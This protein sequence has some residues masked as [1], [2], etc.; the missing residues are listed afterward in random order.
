ML[1]VIDQLGVATN[2]GGRFACEKSH[3][4]HDANA[5]MSELVINGHQ[6]LP[7]GRKRQPLVAHAKHSRRRSFR[8]T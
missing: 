1:D 4:C 2:T 8:R 7:I 3:V 6:D 5:A